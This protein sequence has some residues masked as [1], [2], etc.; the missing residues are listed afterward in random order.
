[1]ISLAEGGSTTSSSATPSARGFHRAANGS[2]SRTAASHARTRASRKSVNPSSQTMGKRV[3]VA[4]MSIR[5]SAATATLAPNLTAGLEGFSES[6]VEG[7]RVVFRNS[8]LCQ[9]PLLCD[10]A[11]IKV[12]SLPVGLKTR[13][14][15]FADL[16]SSQRKSA[17]ENRSTRVGPYYAPDRATLP[18][19]SKT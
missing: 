17:L 5:V 10:T 8:E 12:T 4:S 9:T 11:L 15:T 1:L 13:L 14:I 16:S 7:I 18:M 3:S 6:T 19:F 2:G